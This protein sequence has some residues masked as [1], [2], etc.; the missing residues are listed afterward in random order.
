MLH[1]TKHEPHFAGTRVCKECALTSDQAETEPVQLL[2]GGSP[3]DPW[4][5]RQKG[6][7]LVQERYPPGVDT[8]HGRD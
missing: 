3:I 5:S 7:E 4:K 6:N 1:I 2:R 8:N